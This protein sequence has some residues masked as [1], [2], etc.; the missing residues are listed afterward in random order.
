MANILYLKGFALIFWT[1]FNI[2]KYL[3]SVRL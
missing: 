1:A 3:P 2:L